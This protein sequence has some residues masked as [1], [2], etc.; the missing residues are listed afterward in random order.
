MRR[1][2]YGFI[3]CI[4]FFGCNND[5]SISNHSLLEGEWQLIRVDFLNVNEWESV[6]YSDDT[7]IFTFQSNGILA[8]EG[9]GN[10]DFPDNEYSYWFGEDYLGG[11]PEG[12][13]LLLVKID[14]EK[15]TYQYQYGEMILGQIYIDGTNRVFIRH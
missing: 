4:L 7:I 12:E 6:D 15:W 8:V 2:F 9:N 10:T 5:D 13:P 11:T 3:V 14:E 1:F